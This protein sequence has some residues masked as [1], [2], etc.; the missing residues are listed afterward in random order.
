ME[1]YYQKLLPQHT[2]QYRNI[3]LDSLKYFPSAFE[4]SYEEESKNTPLG[5]E[6]YITDKLPDRFAS[7][8]FKN[9][10]LIG[11]CS[12]YRNQKVKTFHRGN[13]IQMFV[14]PANQGNNIGFNL[15]TSTIKQAFSLPGLEQIELGVATTN[16]SAIKIYKK[17]GFSPFGTIP[18]CLK[19]NET[20]I[21]EMLMV[22]YKQ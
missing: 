12:F 8:A 7:G 18:H 9:D 21:D 6:K 14:L 11:I 4:S 16:T 19:I 20:Y 5:F 22:L 3:R 2:V 13:I 1:I 17:A 15:L 10:Q